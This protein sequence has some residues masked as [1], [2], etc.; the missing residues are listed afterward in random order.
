MFKITTFAR[1]R[2]GHNKQLIAL[3]WLFPGTSRE[4]MIYVLYFCESVR[5][6]LFRFHVIKEPLSDTYSKSAISIL[7]VQKFSTKIHTNS[8]SKGH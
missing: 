6:V 5:K 7:K 2:V 4:Q 1:D 3:K 8:K